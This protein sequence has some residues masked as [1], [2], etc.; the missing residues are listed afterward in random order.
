MGRKRLPHVR[1]EPSGSSINLHVKDQ[2]VIM[3]QRKGKGTAGIALQLGTEAHRL[4]QLGKA[5]DIVCEALQV[6]H[7]DAWQLV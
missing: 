4:V 7:H 2:H 3:Q 5:T 6:Q 1:R